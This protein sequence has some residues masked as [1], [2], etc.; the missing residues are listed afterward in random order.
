MLV[1]GTSTVSALADAHGQAPLGDGDGIDADVLA[2]DDDARLFVDDDARHLVG[3]DVELLDVGEQAGHVG[4][5]AR[6]DR[7]ADGRRI[8]RTRDR[9]AEKGVDR[10][11]HAARRRQVGIAQ[12][13]VELLERGQ[14]EPHLA[15][16]D[17]AVGNAAAGRHALADA[18]SRIARDVEA[19][20]VDLTLRDR[21]DLP[22]R[23]HQGRHQE[24]AAQEIRGVAQGADR[25]VDAC[26]LAREGEQRRGHHGGG[27]VAGVE[28]D[29]P[30][31]DAEPLEHGDKALLGE[32]RVRQAVARPLEPDDQAVADE[33][34]VADAL[35]V[36]DVLD[37]R[38]GEGRIDRRRHDGHRRHGAD[39]GSADRPEPRPLR[40]AQPRWLPT[41]PAR[42]RA[43]AGLRPSQANRVPGPIRRITP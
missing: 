34:V 16:D 35:D 39:H 37:A 8:E 25:R 20:D 19:A 2:D 28:V 27:D 9:L 4:A 3:L 11:G 22:V 23:A 12:G 7:D 30:G 14:L 15:L 38:C 31:V 36:D 10:L 26:A 32:R 42:A 43:L 13:K 1:R 33:Q 21:I 29:A 17:G 18:G 6:R 24:R 5:A 41:S 40:H